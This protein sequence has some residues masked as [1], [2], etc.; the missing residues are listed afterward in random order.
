M[1]YFRKLRSRSLEEALEFANS[2]DASASRVRSALKIFSRTTATG[3]DNINLR[4]MADLP[5][6]ALHQLGCLF[7]QSIASL[8]VPV[9][10]LLNILG[11][12][13]KKQGGSRTIA[14]M[15]SFYRALMK[16]FCPRIREWDLKESHFWDSALAGNS[17][18]RA[19][20]LRAL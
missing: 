7:K 15:A 6:V 2:I 12:L 20:V 18:L 8:K 19:A 13:G 10:E 1:K 5:D 4:R 17:S 9:Q 11:L 14:I 3:S 16:F